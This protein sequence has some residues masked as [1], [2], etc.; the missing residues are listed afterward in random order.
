MNSIYIYIDIISL[1]RNIKLVF[2]DFGVLEVVSYNWW[3]EYIYIFINSN[4]K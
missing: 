1:K 2:N 4:L 3:C